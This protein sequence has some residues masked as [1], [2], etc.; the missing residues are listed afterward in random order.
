M[1]TAS[2]DTLA[3]R[4]TRIESRVRVDINLYPRDNLVWVNKKGF[5]VTYKEGD[6]ADLN[7]R[8][9][10]TLE[11]VRTQVLPDLTLTADDYQD[12][13]IK[14]RDIGSE[15]YALLPEEMGDYICELEADAGDRG[16]SL[17]FAVPPGMDFLWQVVYTG[18]PLDAVETDK[19]WGFR[20]PI[21]HLFWE[22]D[23]R[24]KIK[25]NG[26]MFA[27]THNELRFS[28]EEIKRLEQVVKE[29]NEQLN[30]DVCV[31]RVDDVIDCEK[32]CSDEIFKY[33]NRDDFQFGLVHFACH[34][35]NPQ[36]VGASQ[37][38]LLL[39]AKQVR[40]ELTLGRFNAL[41]KKGGFRHRPLVFLN[42]C[43]SAAPLHF[44]QALNFPS[45]LVNF[46]AGG[47]IAT[48]CTMPDEFAGA[49]ASDFYQKLLRK[50]EDKPVFIGETLMETSRSFLT[51]HNPLGLAYGSYTVSNQ[52]LQL[53]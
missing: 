1:T 35:V 34:C 50:S 24:D 37:A 33:F 10:T 3:P 16:I 2:T 22:S 25:L 18:D 53:E 27:S 32:I 12:C 30:R 31:Q 23:L 41:A 48:V 17:D 36:D 46:G 19:F 7:K 13:L 47:V 28:L 20:Y 39:T 4:T 43:E 8:F 11:E 40:L 42:A 38:Y 44:L 5:K 52:Q 29:I 15:V 21:G 45:G 6:V 51:K 26:G 14:L 9:I 49:F